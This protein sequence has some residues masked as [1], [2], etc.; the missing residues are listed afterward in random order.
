MLFPVVA[1]TS[2]E[3][4][5]VSI[6]LSCLEHVSE[7]GRLLLGELGVRTHSRSSI[8]TW[9]EVNLKKTGS[10]A[11]R[12]D[13]LMIVRN[14]EMKWSA[15]VEAKIG[16]AELTAEQVEAY[17]DLAKLNGVDGLITIS[18]QFAP[19]P[20]HYP[21]AI[22]P[23][24]AKKAFLSHWS[25]TDLLTKAEIILAKGQ[26]RDPVQTQVLTQ[27]ARFLGNPASGVQGYD[28]MPPAWTDLVGLVQSRT[29]ITSRS[30]EVQDVV[31]AWHQKTQDLS[32]RLSRRYKEKVVVK[33]PKAHAADSF[34]RTRS[35]TATLVETHCVQSDFAIPGAVGP[36][37]VTCDFG[38][39]A[40]Y[41]STE[42]DAPQDRKSTKA[43]VNWLLRQLERTSPESVH[44]R[45]IWPGKTPYTQFQLET[46]RRAPEIAEIA[47]KAVARFE[48]I[49]V[50]DLGGRFLKR[51][52]FNGELEGVYAFF[53]EIGRNLKAWQPPKVREA[54]TQTTVTVETDEF[55]A[56]ATGEELPSVPSQSKVQSETH[57]D[58]HLGETG[59]RPAEEQE[60]LSILASAIGRRILPVPDAATTRRLLEFRLPELLVAQAASIGTANR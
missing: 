30:I 11:L 19:Y 7:Y 9:T 49:V 45:L 29:P 31:S 34:E 4:R 15:L 12:P 17:L 1:D 59:G 32:A 40:I 47:G 48:V 46:L 52:N 24:A 8:E 41:F 57:L 23:V 21:L 43:R 18:N 60:V 38:K 13:G 51:K 20:S 3:G 27:L 36:V 44:I 54:G 50:R 33:I 5:A 53:E 37:S 58:F 42:L 55:E 35:D 28:L 14:G 6:F 2:R 39:R 10:K 16:P 56:V 25:W 22:S 26:V